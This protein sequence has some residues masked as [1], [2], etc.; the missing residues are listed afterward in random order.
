MVDIRGRF[1]GLTHGTTPAVVTT[2]EN[3]KMNSFE[4]EKEGGLDRP[5]SDDQSSIQSYLVAIFS[6]RRGD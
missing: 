6:N 2:N 3:I 5:V 1:L 4:R